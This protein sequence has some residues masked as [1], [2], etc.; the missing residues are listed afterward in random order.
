MQDPVVAADGMTYERA[1]IEGW[2]A[3]QRAAGQAPSSPLT[4]APLAS[5]VLHPSHLV[6]SMVASLQA[7]G[8]L[9]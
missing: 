6:R 5:A 8:L 4:G 3:R 7:A 1:A 2:I 9:R